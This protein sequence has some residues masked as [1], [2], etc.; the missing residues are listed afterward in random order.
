MS[1]VLVDSDVLIDVLRRRKSGVIEDWSDLANSNQMVYY[2]PV[3][4]AELQ[5]G[6]REA[7]RQTVE[8]LFSALACVPIGEEIGYK[9][10]VYLRAFQKSHSLALG[11]AL[12]AATA[13]VHGLV[14]WTQN[15]KQFPMKDLSFFRP[16]RL[17]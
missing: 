8:Q 5:H 7:E 2:S 1:G 16:Q 13:N 10:G 14:F 9:A 3:S 6:M 15:L 17:Q 11:D 12:L 4:V